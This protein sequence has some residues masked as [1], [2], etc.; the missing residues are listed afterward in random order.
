MNIEQKFYT[1][2]YS[3]P[4]GTPFYVGKGTGKRLINHMWDAKAGRNTD[5]FHI[6]VI[7]KLLSEGKEPIVSK[8]IDNID[9]ELAFLVEQEFI[10]KYGRRNN[11]SGILTNN[12]NGGEGTFGSKGIKRTPE[13]IAAMKKRLTGVKQKAESIAKRTLALTG[14][15][16]KKI[17]CPHC[18]TTGGETAMKKWH[19]SNCTGAKKFRAR[20]YV[21]G[22][23]YHIGRY[24]TLEDVEIAKKEFIKKKLGI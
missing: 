18:E 13:Q 16:H 8:I 23:R 24:A 2:T 11:G 3:Y 14:Y 4:N 20:A 22:K 7:R 12:T 1:Y 19:F 9:E 17:T 5:K 6:R 15:I 10:S 21:N